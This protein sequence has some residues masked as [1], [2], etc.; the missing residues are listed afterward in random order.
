MSVWYNYK[1]YVHR[2]VLIDLND[3]PSEVSYWRSAVFCNILTYLTPL[4]LI[5]LVPSVIMSFMT[6]VVVIG[7]ADIARESE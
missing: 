5:A 4:S 1:N 6:D 3:R 2:V 7:V